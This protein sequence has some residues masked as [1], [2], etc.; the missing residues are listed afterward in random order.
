[1]Q[2]QGDSLLAAQSA[3]RAFTALADRIGEPFVLVTHSQAGPF[4]WQL[5]DARPELVKGI[6]AIEPGASPFETWTGPPFAPGYAPPWPPLRYGLTLLPLQY[7]P[8]LPDDDPAALTRETHRPSGPN[9]A[10]YILQAEPA[11]QLPNLAKVKVLQ[12]IGEASFHAVFSDGVAAYLRQAG[13]DFEFVRLEER[14]IRGNGHFL[15]MEKNNIEI[16]EK[17]V[18]PFL[19]GLETS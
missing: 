2:Y 19:Q 4:G 10:P 8:P 11:R 16:A 7:N 3:D 14:G 13:V 17:V 6:V 18:L 9:R 15:F 1:M 5:A 12:I